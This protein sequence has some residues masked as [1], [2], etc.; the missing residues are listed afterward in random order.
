M[1]RRQIRL[2]GLGNLLSPGT[3]DQEQMDRER[4]EAVKA[5]ADI[6]HGVNGKQ[7]IIKSEDEKS[8]RGTLLSKNISK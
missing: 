4:Q 5:V 6:T 8:P 3:P 2:E 7:K 1:T